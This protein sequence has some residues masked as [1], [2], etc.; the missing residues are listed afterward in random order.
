MN[1]IILNK[2]NLNYTKFIKWITDNNVLMY[3]MHTTR[4][5]YFVS[6]EDYVAFS[7][8]FSKSQNQN[9]LGSYYCPYVPP[10]MVLNEKTN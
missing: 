1:H 3:T 8:T 4:D 7:L 2:W 6:D 9:D 10:I 5:V